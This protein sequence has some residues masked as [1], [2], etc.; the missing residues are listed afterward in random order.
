MLQESRVVEW[1]AG[2]LAAGFAVVR[3]VEA[4]PVEAV[5]GS[6]STE[7]VVAVCMAEAVLVTSAEQ[8]VAACLPPKGSPRKYAVRCVVYTCPYPSYS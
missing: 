7:S 1:L 6:D 5:D 8:A 4:V 2:R 3:E